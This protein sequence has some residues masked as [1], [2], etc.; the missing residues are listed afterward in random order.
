MQKVLVGARF[1]NPPNLKSYKYAWV[2][3]EVLP[4]KFSNRNKSDLRLM[5]KDVV[6]TVDK[7][8]TSNGNVSYLFFKTDKFGPVFAESFDCSRTFDTWKHGDIVRGS[9]ITEELPQKNWRAFY[10]DKI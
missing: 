5:V 7:N 9:I 10:V 8:I 3:I 1:S 6:M 2:A 4:Y